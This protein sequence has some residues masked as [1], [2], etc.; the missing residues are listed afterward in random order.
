M[1][2]AWKVVREDIFELKSKI[3]KVKKDLE[4]V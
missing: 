4:G 3:L 2:R 1:K